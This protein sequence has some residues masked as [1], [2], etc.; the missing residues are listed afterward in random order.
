MSTRTPPLQPRSGF[1]RDWGNYANAFNALP[2]QAANPLAAAQHPVLEAGDRAFAIS[3]VWECLDPGT[4]GGGDAVWRPVGPDIVDTV[5]GFSLTDYYEA[6]PAVAEG[7][8][9]FSAVWYG[10]FIDFVDGAGQ[11]LMGHSSGALNGGWALGVGGRIAAGDVTVVE[12]TVIEAGPSFTSIS[13]TTAQPFVW[14]RAQPLHVA[15]AYDE[16][17]AGLEAWING[18]RCRFSP[19]PATGAFLPSPT[20]TFKVGLGGFFGNEPALNQ[21]FIGGGYIDGAALTAAQVQEHLQ[22]CRD[23]GFAFA[24]GALTWTHRWDV[25]TAQALGGIATLPDLGGGGGDL[26]AAGAPAARARRV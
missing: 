15:L 8:G 23:E 6:S 24:E 19:T 22:A 12:A 20:G 10:Y 2:N 1:H 13:E 9:L 3:R 16:L 21:G 11:F 25:R 4:A 14:H 26:T 5:E 18:V 17:G 7:S